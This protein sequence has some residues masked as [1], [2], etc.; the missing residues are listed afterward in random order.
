[1][2]NYDVRFN[3]KTTEKRPACWDWPLN[4]VALNLAARAGDLPRAVNALYVWQDGM[5]AICGIAEYDVVDHD[6][7]TGLVRGLLCAGCNSAE[8]RYKGK[9]A[10]FQNYAH[11]NPAYI[12]D[13]RVLYGPLRKDQRPG[14]ASKSYRPAAL[15]ASPQN[16]F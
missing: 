2:A 3:R 7:Q 16:R 14:Q 10:L 11:I 1:M 4:D 8:G 6:H 9:L 12:L 13:I 5:C 15:C